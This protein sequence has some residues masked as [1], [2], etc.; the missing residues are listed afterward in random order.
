MSIIDFF[1]LF[2]NT[3]NILKLDFAL[4]SCMEF[5]PPEPVHNVTSESRSI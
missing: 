4:V 1:F 5:C 3:K 2:K